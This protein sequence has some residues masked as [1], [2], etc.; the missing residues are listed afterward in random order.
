[1][2]EP[3]LR[4]AREEADAVS[5]KAAKVR[6]QRARDDELAGLRARAANL[7]AEVRA[8]RSSWSWRV[9]APLRRIYEILVGSGR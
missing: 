9:S 1:M 5:R 2:L 7:D 6:E 3:A 8:L 4:R